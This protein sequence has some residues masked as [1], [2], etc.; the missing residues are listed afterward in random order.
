MN[1]LRIYCSLS[2]PAQHCQW[3]LIDDGRQSI[4]GE[5][6]LA[7][8]PRRAER[9]QLVIPASQVLITRARVP[10][11]ARRGPGSVLAF[12]VE[13][14]LAG[15]PDGSQVSWLGA[16]GDEDAL[17]VTDKRGLERWRQALADAGIAVD[18]VHC[19]TLLLPLRAGE[20]SLAW[21]GRDGFVRSGEFEGTSTD[22]GDRESPPLCLRLMLEE[23]GARGATPNA[24]AL[25]AT[26]PDATP[27]LAAWQRELGTELRHAGAWDWRLAPSAAGVCLTQPRQGWRLLADAARRLRPAA[28]ILGLALALH[29]V[30][31]VAGWTQL[32]GEQQALRQ[33]MEA[34][35]RA[36]FPAAVAVADPVLQMRRKLADARHGAGV[37]DSGDFLPMIEQVAAATRELPPGALR[38]IAYE[39]GQMRLE[40]VVNDGAA[41]QRLKARLLD[42]GLSVELA[43]TTPRAG[44]ATQLMTVRAP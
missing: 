33:K 12:A 30:A 28:W 9:V 25:Y 21:N 13:E 6:R 23:A 17:A 34:Q 4:T 16:V 44:R 27:D 39:G 11:E 8:L 3:A 29:A 36:A 5:G 19:E 35:F 1:L 18:E 40:L 38:T 43:A 22:C 32:A 24:I 15:D 41:V 20:W 14:R 10:R 31:L 26:P 42:S 2:A 7:D 37:A